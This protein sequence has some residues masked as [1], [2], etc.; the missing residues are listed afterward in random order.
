MNNLAQPDVLDLDVL[1][2]RYGLQTNS[3]NGNLQPVKKPNL[4]V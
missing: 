4:F 1:R 3:F 2:L